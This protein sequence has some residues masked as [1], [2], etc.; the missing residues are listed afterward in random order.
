MRLGTDYNIKGTVSMLSLMWGHIA[1]MYMNLISKCKLQP[2]A[3]DLNSILQ[4]YDIYSCLI[5]RSKF[6]LECTAQACLCNGMVKCTCTCYLQEVWLHWV[7]KHGVKCSAILFTKSCVWN[8][9]LLLQS[10]KMQS[11]VQNICVGCPDLY[12]WGIH[13][14]GHKYC[15]FRLVAEARCVTSS[16][17]RR[18]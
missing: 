3:N 13:L 18:P 12:N 17:T 9:F 10:R 6:V 16:V 15:A 2:K 11:D 14:L 5:M 7:N 8:A 4:N 1:P